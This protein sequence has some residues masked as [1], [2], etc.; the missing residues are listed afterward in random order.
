MSQYLGLNFSTL[1][2][3]VCRRHFEILF[4]FSQK[5]GFNISCKLSP[6]FFHKTGSDISCKLSPN[7]DNLHEMSEPCFLGKI[8]K[9]S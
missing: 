9:V 5:A 6:L 8:R 4:Y 3:I 7:G 1:G 2:K